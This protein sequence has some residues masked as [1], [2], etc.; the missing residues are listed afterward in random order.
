MAAVTNT[1]DNST[2]TFSSRIISSASLLWRVSTW[3]CFAQN[4][5]KLETLYK[6]KYSLVRAKKKLIIYWNIIIII[7][8]IIVIGTRALCEPW[9]SSELFAILPYCRSVRLLL[10]WIWKQLNFYGVK[11]LASCPTSHL[12]DQCLPLHLSLTPW[13]V[14]PGWPYQ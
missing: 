1:G 8:I 12:E 14:R 9:P 4:F 10:L 3:T 13:P 6:Q 7:I 2:E 11:L 5:S